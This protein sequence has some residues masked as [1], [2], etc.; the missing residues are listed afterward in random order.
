MPATFIVPE[1]ADDTAVAFV[2]PKK[3]APYARA[4]PAANGREGE[5]L[6]DF[7]CRWICEEGVRFSMRTE[8]ATVDAQR[9]EDSRVDHLALGQEMTDLLL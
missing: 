3:L 5:A 1:D 4:L 2:L 6:N 9:T 7:I 8:I